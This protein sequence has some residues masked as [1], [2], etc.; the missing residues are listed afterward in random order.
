[1]SDQ[2]LSCNDSTGTIKVVKGSDNTLNS[3][4][5]HR[6]NMKHAKQWVGPG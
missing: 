4:Q 3:S 1:M 2:D 6:W 5:G